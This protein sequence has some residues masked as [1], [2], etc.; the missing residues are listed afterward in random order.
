MEHSNTAWP[1]MAPMTA[2][3]Q[4]ETHW[5]RTL[6]VDLYSGPR[7]RTLRRAGI[8]FAAFSVVVLVTLTAFLEATVLAQ[9]V[10]PEVAAANVVACHVPP[11]KPKHA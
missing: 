7:P 8:A 5:T 2:E 10:S 1:A 4:V 6:Y 9:V 11:P 3:P